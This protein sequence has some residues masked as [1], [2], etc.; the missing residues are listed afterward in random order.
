MKI[1][2]KKRGFNVPLS[3]WIRTDLNDNF[4]DLLRSKNLLDSFG[5]NTNTIDELLKSHQCEEKD[6][7]WPLFTLYSLFYWKNSL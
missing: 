5:F 3:K 1:D 6:Y 2:N 7:K 4:N